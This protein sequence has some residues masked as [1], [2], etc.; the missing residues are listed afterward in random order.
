MYLRTHRDLV[1]KCKRR[2]VA[3]LEKLSSVRRISIFLGSEISEIVFYN[4]FAGTAGE[5]HYKANE[6][7]WLVNFM[8]MLSRSLLTAISLSVFNMVD[9]H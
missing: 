7:L 3:K 4:K 2:T 8:S 6:Y 5:S 1:A 9:I